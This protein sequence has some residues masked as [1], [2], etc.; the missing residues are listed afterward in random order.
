MKVSLVDLV[1]D[2]HLVLGQRPILLDLPEQQ[3][4]GQ[5]EQLGGRGPGGLKAD[6]VP[7][8]TSNKKRTIFNNVQM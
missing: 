2:H 6:L 3:A 7:D 8:L 4:F 1:H 5:E